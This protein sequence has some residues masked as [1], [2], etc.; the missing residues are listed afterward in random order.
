[1]DW[2]LLQVDLGPRTHP[3]GT[4]EVVVV[5][6]EFDILTPDLLLPIPYNKYIVVI[7]PQGNA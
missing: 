2:L 5:C 4:V 7:K 3:L 6:H 1:M